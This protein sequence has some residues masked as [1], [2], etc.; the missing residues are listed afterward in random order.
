AARLFRPMLFG[1]RPDASASADPTLWLLAMLIRSVGVPF[2]IVSTPAPLLQNWLAKTSTA[3]GRDPYFLYAVSN[4]G[5]LL[6]LLAYPLVIEPRFGVRWQSETWLAAYGVLVALVVA[7]A[8][9]VWTHLNQSKALMRP[10]GQSA[11]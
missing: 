8:A 7:A 1:A 6:A 4:A 9:I 2:C 3:S 5:S 10:A 11:G